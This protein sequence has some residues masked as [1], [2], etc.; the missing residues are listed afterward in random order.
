[1]E[2][3]RRLIYIERI[4]IRWG[5]M[6]AYGH[7]NNTVYFRFMEQARVG[8]MQ[9]LGLDLVAP[10]QGPVIVTASCAFLKQLDY[11]GT[12]EVRMYAGELGRSS[13]MSYYELRREGEE[14]LCATGEAK[15]VWAD[16]RVRKSMPIPPHIRRLLEA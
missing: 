7:V 1:M 2:K 4:P 12:V 15:I 5:D 10:E 3:K 11:P 6:D 9:E 16:Q 14:E 8:W 13:L